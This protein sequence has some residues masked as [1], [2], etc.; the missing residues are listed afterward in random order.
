MRRRLA[1]TSPK[2]TIY[3]MRAAPLDQVMR[4]DM[5]T[6]ATLTRYEELTPAVTA[7]RS[8]TLE[9]CHNLWYIPNTAKTSRRSGI[10]STMAYRVLI[11]ASRGTTASNLMRSPTISARARTKASRTR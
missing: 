1:P 10:V 6:M 7:I 3:E 9:Y 8:L 5:A 2:A 11:A 4:G